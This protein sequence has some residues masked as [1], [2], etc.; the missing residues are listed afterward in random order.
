MFAIIEDSGSQIKVSEGDVIDI[1]R[2][3]LGD[4]DIALTF[5]RVVYL[6]SDE[7]QAPTIGAP[8]VN[9][10]KVEADILEEGRGPKID[11]VKFK[12]RKTYKR[13]RGHRQDFIRVRVTSISA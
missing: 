2:R 9:G 1:D 5:D 10:A 11:V 3:E 4:E 7:D 8:Y 6:S 12:R 13:K